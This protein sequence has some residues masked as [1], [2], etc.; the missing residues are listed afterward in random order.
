MQNNGKV[1]LDKLWKSLGSAERAIVTRKFGSFLRN[2]KMNGVPIKHEMRRALEELMRNPL[3]F[4][5]AAP[6][7]RIGEYEGRDYKQLYS[8]L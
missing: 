7:P 2:S 8:E 5:E 4:A 6:E 3:E 1:D